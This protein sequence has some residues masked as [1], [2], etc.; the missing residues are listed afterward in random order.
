MSCHFRL[1]QYQIESVAVILNEEYNPK[2]KTHTGDLTATMMVSPH[3]QDPQKFML[4]LEILAR[5]KKDHETKFF[6][7]NIAVKGRAFFVF[8]DKP[9]KNEAEKTLRLNGAAILYGLLRGQIAQITAQS[10]HGQFL[11]PTMNF[12]ELQEQA[13]ETEPPKSKV[14]KKAATKRTARGKKTKK[15]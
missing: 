4:I 12:V 14:K 11:L 9:E 13:L 15:A 1:D 2:L 3:N 6:P 8:K 10:V 5:P 7:Y